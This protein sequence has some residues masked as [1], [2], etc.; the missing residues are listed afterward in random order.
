MLVPAAA[1][2]TIDSAAGR[3]GPFLL[4]TLPSLGTVTWACGRSS[5]ETM[6]A[7]GYEASARYATTVL[8]L[9]ASR[10]RVSHRVV[11]PGRKVRFPF[12]AARVQ[13]L[14]FV[15]RTG[16]GE[17]RASVRVDFVPGTSSSYCFE[18]QPPRISVQISPR[19]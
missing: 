19:Q 10:R 17:L 14:S 11:Q 1:A 13:A 15:Q 18:Y 12:L 2:P 5:G 9:R 6:F 16:A 7:L 3:R 4:V 8:E